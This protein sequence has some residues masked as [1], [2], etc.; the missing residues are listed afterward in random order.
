MGREIK[1][2]TEEKAIY[3]P[4]EEI[5]V[6]NA[7]EIREELSEMID[8]GVKEIIIDL[9]NVEYVDSSGLGVLVSTMKRLKKI[10]GKMIL[11]SP[12]NAIK[13]VLELTSLDKVFTIEYDESNIK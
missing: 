1:K 13:Q 2:I 12:K 3:I 4:T 7:S 8:N 10:N 9:R 11:L 6:Y 5:E